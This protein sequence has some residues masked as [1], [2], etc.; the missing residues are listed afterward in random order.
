MQ[1]GRGW[2]P[3]LWMQASGYIWLIQTDINYKMWVRKWLLS[4]NFSRRCH[5]NLWGPL[6]EFIKFSCLCF[7]DLILALILRSIRQAII[8][9][10]WRKTRTGVLKGFSWCPRASSWQKLGCVWGGG[11]KVSGS[12]V[13]GSV[14]G[15]RLWNLTSS[16]LISVSVPANWVSWGKFLNL[17][18]APFPHLR[19]EHSNT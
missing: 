9:P 8:I 15:R 6:S 7:K 11:V 5:W 12:S 17:S 13:W 10:G 1:V 3:I 18:E 19:N 16:I 4:V 2:W 14:M